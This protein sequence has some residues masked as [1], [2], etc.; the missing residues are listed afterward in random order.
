MELQILR[1]LIL[2]NLG[3]DS[4]FDKS[5]LTDS[6]I[7]QF[8]E[9]LCQFENEAKPLYALIY[10]LELSDPEK[11]ISKLDTIYQLFIN[12]IAE[13]FVVSNNE[14]SFCCELLLKNQ[15]QSFQKRVLF[16]QNVEKVIKKVERQRIKDSLSTSWEALAFEI[17]EKKL[18][19]VIKKQSREK[20]K[21]QFK[22]WDDELN[23]EKVEET[24]IISF[25]WIKY[26]VAACVL[27]L[28]G[29]WIFNTLQKDV[30]PKGTM[31]LSSAEKQKKQ[32]LREIKQIESRGLV[33]V[34][35]NQKSVEI[36]STRGVGYIN[37]TQKLKIVIK[38][39]QPRINSIIQAIEQYQKLLETKFAP[40]SF[41]SQNKLFKELE[42]KIDSLKIE[43]SSLKSMQN[44]YIFDGKMVT[45]H[46]SGNG[47][48]H[49]LFSEDIYYLKKENSIY[50]LVQTTQ[51]KK[52]EKLK[53]SEKQAALSKI[54]FDN[55]F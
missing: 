44:T 46:T 14:K 8:A 6:F 15:N 33:D 25:S 16:Y 2:S 31:E 13:H 41:S 28:V 47:K 26:A 35:S 32:I 9:A 49:I 4:K 34:A 53:D 23:K 20:L 10:S 12:E 22:K 3:T 1:E 36:L 50:P 24:K 7:E 43:L 30:D 11:G 17:P 45:L 5:L 40:N 37:K 39:P 42:N 27:F 18:E 19:N 21:Q 54:L 51:P 48:I 29:F 55:G 38:D 52:L